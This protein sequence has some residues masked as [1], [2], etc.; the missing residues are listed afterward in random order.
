MKLP[1]PI[2]LGYDRMFY[3][4]IC[5]RYISCSSMLFTLYQND[6][7]VEWLANMVTHY[8]HAHSKEYNKFISKP[9][10]EIEYIEMKPIFNE[11]AKRQ[12]ARKCFDYMKHYN[13]GLRELLLLTNNTAQTVELYEVL[14]KEI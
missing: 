3:C 5:K 6:A 10:T 2:T 14:F 13:I 11:T 1:K 9:L 8:R 12:I 7:R 4:S